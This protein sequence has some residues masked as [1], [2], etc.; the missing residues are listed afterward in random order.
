MC[1]LREQ[2][3]DQE[4]LIA[5]VVRG[6]EGVRKE[7]ES[8]SQK[9][10]RLEQSLQATVLDIQEFAK[11]KQASLNQ[12]DVTVTMHMHQIEYLVDGRIPADNASAL[13][14]S[15]DELERLR[16]RIDVRCCRCCCCATAAATVRVRHC[17]WRVLG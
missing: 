7:R 1:A 16:R 4:D 10:K 17:A 5:D 3:L 11:E 9:L 15:N 14:F 13:V 6:S 8:Q 2:R 12:I